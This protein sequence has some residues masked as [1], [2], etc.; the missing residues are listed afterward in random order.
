M[1]QGA[2]P[3]TGRSYWPNLGRLGLNPQSLPG[4]G[5]PAVSVQKVGRPITAE[6]PAP[7]LPDSLASASQL[8]STISCTRGHLPGVSSHACPTQACSRNLRVGE[9]D[10]LC[11]RKLTDHLRH[12]ASADLSWP[13]QLLQLIA[14]PSGPKQPPGLGHIPLSI[15]K[16]MVPASLPPTDPLNKKRK[17]K[18]TNEIKSPRTDGT[19]K[20]PTPGPTISSPRGEVVPEPAA[21]VR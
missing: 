12:R 1:R 21:G 11:F 18:R 17:T 10:R 2:P 3:L 6:H 19:R 5:Q 13:T 7:P 9:R 8:A 14:P 4:P 15:P 16:P 20:I